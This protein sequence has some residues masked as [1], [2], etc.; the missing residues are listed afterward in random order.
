MDLKTYLTQNGLSGLEFA[1]RVGTDPAQ[2]SR[3]RNGKRG[4]KLET[5]LAIEYHT[6]GEVT[7]W[8]WGCTSFTRP[9]RFV[10]LWQVEDLDAMVDAERKRRA[11]VKLAEIAAGMGLGPEDMAKP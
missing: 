6:N 8:D 9:A 2:V 7:C 3:H 1:A 5:A 10:D 4:P 11:K